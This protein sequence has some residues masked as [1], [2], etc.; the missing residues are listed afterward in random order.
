MSHNRTT[1]KKVSFV[2]KKQ[3][4]NNINTFSRSGT[5]KVSILKHKGKDSKTDKTMEV[6]QKNKKI[7]VNK[8]EL[9]LNDI[10]E[11]ESVNINNNKNNNN[12]D[13]LKYLPAD[14]YFKVTI[15]KDLEQ[16][17]LNIAILHPADPIKFLGNYLI[18]KS[19]NNSSTS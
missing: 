18:E 1:T 8:I 11:E 9:K 19:K 13:K 12:N 17:L 16:G 4:N 14:E 10:K 2:D 5:K 6:I 7:E 15:Q 3:L